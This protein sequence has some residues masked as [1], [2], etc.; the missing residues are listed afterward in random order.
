MKWW[1][2]V[3]LLLGLSIVS[4]AQDMPPNLQ[5]DIDENTL[6]IRLLEDM[7]LSGLVLQYV[8]ARGQAQTYLLTSIPDIQL[9]SKAGDCLM[10]VVEQ[11]IGPLECQTRTDYPLPAAAG[12]WFDGVNRRYIT[13]TVLNGDVL[14]FLC[15]AKLTA[16]RCEG[17]YDDSID[18]PSSV[19]LLYVL[20]N[21]DSQHEIWRMNADG[22]DPQPVIVSSGNDTD[23]HWSPRTQRL[24]FTSTRDGNSEIY[25][26]ALDGTQ[27]QNLTR[28]PAEDRSPVWSADG[29]QILFVS[30]AD[31]GS[32]PEQDWELWVMDA[33]GS[34][35]RQLTSNDAADVDPA[36]SPDGQWIAFVRL[37]ANDTYDL[38]V[39]SAD[40]RT[41]QNI[42]NTN[43]V[44]E[45]SPDWSTPNQLIYTSNTVKQQFDLYSASL[46][47]SSVPVVLRDEKPLT[48]TLADESSPSGSADGQR[49]A[50]VLDTDGSAQ[51]WV[52]DLAEGLPEMMS[53]DGT[54]SLQPT[55]ISGE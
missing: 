55:W 36:W 15:A 8:N 53:I 20:Q 2:V 9:I 44:N 31:A 54:R 29:Q 38:Y 3:A 32:N 39:M 30:N 23:P 34:H 19:R 52:M 47:L 37:E 43:T 18:A 49:V 4:Y 5:I 12:F 14:Q 6:V 33:D 16:A 35:R 46:D 11:T 27:L 10:L 42:T 17:Y 48:E 26:A 13:L 45:L 28:D 22:S 51:I 1:G 21:Q 40:G 24:V 7:D 25:T 41:P 50:Y